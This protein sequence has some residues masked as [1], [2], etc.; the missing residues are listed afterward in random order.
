[1]G[2]NIT[3]YTNTGLTANTSYSYRVRASN[4]GGDSAYSNI[5]TATTKAAGAP[6]LTLNGGATPITVAPGA[7]ITIRVVNPT[8]NALDWIG[9]YP[10]GVAAGTTRSV[11]EHYVAGTAYTIPATTPPGIYEARLFANDTVTVRV[12]SAAIV[13]Q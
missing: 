1:M 13:V 9:I 11:V 10:V 6:S 3:Y 8:G 4:A 2:A 7:T 5:A 12:T